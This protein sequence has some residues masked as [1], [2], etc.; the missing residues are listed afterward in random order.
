MRI[1]TKNAVFCYIWSLVLDNPTNLFI[2]RVVFQSNKSPIW[3][4]GNFLFTKM[5]KK[6]YFQISILLYCSNRTNG[7]NSKIMLYLAHWSLSNNSKPYFGNFGEI[8]LLVM[9]FLKN[10]AKN[11][12]FQPFLPLIPSNLGINRFF[13]QILV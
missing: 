12:D 13:L 2:I 10:I 4:E 11:V 7:I 8:L 6:H 5:F 1:R 9:N 3:Y